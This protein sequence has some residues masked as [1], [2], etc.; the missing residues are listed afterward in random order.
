[1]PQAVV[2]SALLVSAGIF[3]GLRAQRPEPPDP[4]ASAS[5]PRVNAAPDVGAPPGDLAQPPSPQPPAP[6]ATPEWEP[7]SDHLDKIR[8]ALTAAIEERREELVRACFKGKGKKAG[9]RR[10]FEFAYRVDADGAALLGFVRDSAAKRD[11]ELEQ[12]LRGAMG[13]RMTIPPPGK[14]AGMPVTLKLP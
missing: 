8:K 6:P 9:E 13:E 3:F 2:L 5:H 12:C 4:S 7:A 11:E 14:P 1:M 10:P